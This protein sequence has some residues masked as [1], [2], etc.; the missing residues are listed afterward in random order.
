[1]TVLYRVTYPLGIVGCSRD[2]HSVFSRR[3]CASEAVIIVTALSLLQ[4]SKIGRIIALIT[5]GVVTNNIVY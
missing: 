1:M 4:L 3:G 5:G 2:M